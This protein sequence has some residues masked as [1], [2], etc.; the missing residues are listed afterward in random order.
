MFL[1]LNYLGPSILSLLKLTEDTF[2]TDL[3]ENTFLSMSHERQT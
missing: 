3:Q 2:A 1:S